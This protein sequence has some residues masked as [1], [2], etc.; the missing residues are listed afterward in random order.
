MSLDQTISFDK[1]ETQE[2][3]F[4][5]ENETGVVNLA[6]ATIDWQL[7]QNGGVYLSLADSGVSIENRNDSAGEFRVR[8]EADATDA[9]P[10]Q[11]YQETIRITEANGN[12]TKEDGR[13]RIE[14]V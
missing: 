8:L 14:E 2:L 10:P 7:S 13:V 6:G 5:V 1:G 12:V 9:L 11:T 3:P 4:V